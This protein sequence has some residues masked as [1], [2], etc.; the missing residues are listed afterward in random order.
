VVYEALTAGLPVVT[1]ANSGSVVRDGLEGFI[2]PIRSSEAI[3]SAIERLDGDRTLLA[4]M[5][6]NAAR[7]AAGF[8]ITSY[9]RR[10]RMALHHVHNLHRKASP[11]PLRRPGDVVATGGALREA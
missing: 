11:A 8:D 7:R 10:L 4:E 3:V 2:V 9:G 6:A 5:S 1:T